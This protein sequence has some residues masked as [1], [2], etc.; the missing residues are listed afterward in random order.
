MR[1]FNRIILLAISCF[2]LPTLAANLHKTVEINNGDKGVFQA[3]TQGDLSQSV[4]NIK[5]EARFQQ[6]Y[7]GARGVKIDGT[8]NA[9]IIREQFQRKALF[10][11]NLIIDVPAS[12]DKGD[13]PARQIKLVFKDLKLQKQFGHRRFEGELMIDGK[14]SKAEDMPLRVQ[15]MIGR[16]VRMMRV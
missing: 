16:L 9:H 5:S 10:D 15:R 12:T 3:S 4:G 2:S 7:M 14:I 11:A 8:M 13:R 1:I 6:F